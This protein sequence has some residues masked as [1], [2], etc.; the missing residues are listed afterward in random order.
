[1][2]YQKIGFESRKKVSAN[3]GTF[4]VY[5]KTNPSITTKKFWVKCSS[6]VK[7]IQTEPWRKKLSYLLRENV[8]FKNENNLY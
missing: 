4:Q 1:M 5:Q 2:F 3:D 8:S 6:T 7:N